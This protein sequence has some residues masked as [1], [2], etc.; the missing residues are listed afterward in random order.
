MRVVFIQLA[1][2]CYFDICDIINKNIGLVIFK[3]YDLRTVLKP[4]MCSGNEAF[5]SSSWFSSFSSSGAKAPHELRLLPPLV[6]ILRL[7]PPISKALYLH[8]LFLWIQQANLVFYYPLV[9]RIWAFCK[10]LSP[11]FNTRISQLPHPS[12]CHFLHKFQFII[13]VIQ[14]TI[15][16]GSPYNM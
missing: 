14:F 6:L 9:Y 7:S 8:S 13:Y 2:I 1:F 12:C 3:I 16:P 11:Q 5:S 10:F 15:K 4:V